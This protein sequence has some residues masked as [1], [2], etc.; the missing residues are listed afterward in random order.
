MTKFEIA[1]SAVFIGFILSQSV[2]LFK[3]RW[4]IYRKKKAVKDE[5]KVLTLEFQE[6]IQRIEEILN[7]LSLKKYNGIPTPSIIPNIIYENHYPEVAPFFS[8][9]ERKAISLI[10]NDV[11]NYNEATERKNSKNIDT[12][13]SLLVELY[14]YC[15]MGKVSSEY[16]NKYGGN[17]LLH[18]DQGKLQEIHDAT[19]KLAGKY[20]TQ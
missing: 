9:N 13:K 15:Q 2:D 18:K 11:K 5:I 19:N 10:Y 6:R 3:Y 1:I 20:L 14:A 16:F 7:D 8:S 4:S 17:N 12:K